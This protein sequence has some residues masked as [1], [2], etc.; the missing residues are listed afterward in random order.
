MARKRFSSIAAAGK[1]RALGRTRFA[2]LRRLFRGQVRQHGDLA[3]WDFNHAQMRA[4]ARSRLAALRLSKPQLHLLIA[5]HL[6]TLA[7][8]DRLRT[9]ETMVH[10]LASKDD[11]RAARYYGDSSLSEAELQGATRALADAMIAPPTGTPASA[12]RDICRLLDDPDSSV[13]AVD[14]GAFPLQSR[15]RD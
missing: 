3:Q 1:R 9:T 12:A 6:L 2:A 10:L 15:R 8:D 13:R 4:A 14:G 7:P 5:D 11:I